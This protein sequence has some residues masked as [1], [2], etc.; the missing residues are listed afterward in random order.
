MHLRIGWY[1]L[2]V[3]QYFKVMKHKFRFVNHCRKWFRHI[4]LLLVL[5]WWLVSN[6][7]A[8][9]SC[10]LVYM[11]DDCNRWQQ[12]II[13]C[14]A[15]HIEVY[16]YA[17]LSIWSYL[18]LKLKH[19]AD[20]TLI[21]IIYYSNTAFFFLTSIHFFVFIEFSSSDSF[22]IVLWYCLQSCPS[23]IAFVIYTS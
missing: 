9:Y 18:M 3:A 2:F 14:D 21:M 6:I 15:Q 22:N 4:G 17:F 20:Y 16:L 12:C 11:V 19:C 8:A 1:C 23:C 10:H 5:V 7:P 13:P